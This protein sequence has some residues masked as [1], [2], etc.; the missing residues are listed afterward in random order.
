MPS[1]PDRFVRIE[2]VTKGYG[3]LRALDD[4]SFS[5]DEGEIFGYIGPN[6][7]GKTTTIKILVG[8]L[9]SFE[10][11]AL[12][13][14]HDV[15]RELP[16]VQRLLGYLPQEAAFQEWRTVDHALTTFGRLS[17]L[18]RADLERR[19]KEVLGLLGIPEVQHR[20]IVQLSGGTAQKVGMAQAILHGPRL[21]VLDEPMAGLDPASRFQFKE[22][23]RALAQDGT[24]IFFSSHILSDVQD[25]ATRVGILNRGRAVH[26]GTLEELKARLQVGRSVEIVLAHDSG[27]RPDF[28]ARADVLGVDRFAENHLVVRLRPDADVDAAIDGF[29]R[30]LL[31][32]GCR[33]RSI[34]PVSP[35]LEELYVRFVAGDRP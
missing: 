1:D 6:G 15:R 34:S 13:D 16:A 32:S 35:N 27:R 24:T 8:I 3:T 20:R 11:T 22:V 26:V 14:G 31:A 4:V 18:S 9:R 29:V 23:F 17:G 2:R 33:I 21:L 19:K 28:A 30:D 12:V 25:V 7:A 5:I 10:G